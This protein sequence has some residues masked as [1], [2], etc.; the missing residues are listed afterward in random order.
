MIAVSRAG[1]LRRIEM[2]REEIRAVLSADD[3]EIVRRYLELHRERLEERLAE[4]QRALVALERS[5]TEAI[6][7]EK[8]R[9]LAGLGTPSSSTFPGTSRSIS[10]LYGVNRIRSSRSLP[11]ETEMA[12]TTPTPSA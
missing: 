11:P 2:P 6:L 5:L 10:H 4:R 1:A 8:A 3:P 12:R 7:Q 9:G